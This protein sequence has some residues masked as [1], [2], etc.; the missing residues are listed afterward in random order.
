MPPMDKGTFIIL[1]GL[2]TTNVV[3]L[4]HDGPYC[5]MMD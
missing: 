3:M 1:A 2:A 5:Q 4:T